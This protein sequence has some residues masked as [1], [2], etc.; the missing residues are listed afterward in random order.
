ME[1]DVLAFPVLVKLECPSVLTYIIVPVSRDGRIVFIMSTPGVS[2]I[3]IYRVAISVQFPH[4]RHRHCVPAACIIIGPVEICRT[5]VPVLIPVEIPCAVEHELESV[6]LEMSR[7][8]DTVLL[9]H[10]RI[11]PCRQG[12]L[13][14]C[15]RSNG[16]GSQHQSAENGCHLDFHNVISFML[17]CFNVT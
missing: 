3:H 11:L 8:R 6:C 14:C 15:R 4:A 13:L 9:D 5:G 10:I 17:Y 1:E 7:H 12:C 2:Y 16:G